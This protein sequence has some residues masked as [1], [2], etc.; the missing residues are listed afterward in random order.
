MAAVNCENPGRKKGNWYPAVPP[1]CRCRTGMGP[2]DYFGRI[3]VA[4]LPE[5]VK[6]GVIVVAVGGCK[7]ELFDKE[8]YQ[9]YVETAPA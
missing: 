7:I 4:I 1:L 2:T 6:V 8:N 9:S 5:N 3:L